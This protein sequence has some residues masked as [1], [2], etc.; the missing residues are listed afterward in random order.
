MFLDGS[1]VLL[2][3]IEIAKA[4]ANRLL[5]LLEGCALTDARDKVLRHAIHEIGFEFL[6]KLNLVEFANSANDE[7]V[8]EDPT[9]RG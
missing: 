2:A 1:I 8:G 7:T 9:D 3:A 4:L 5:S 6:D